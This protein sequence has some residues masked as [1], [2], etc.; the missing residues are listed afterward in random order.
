[1]SGEKDYWFPAKKYGWGWGIPTRWQG[2]FVIAAYV[3]SFAL[4][5]WFFPPGIHTGEFV[6]GIFVAS[7]IFVAVCWLKGEPPKWRWGDDGQSRQ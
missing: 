3:V 1:M 4:I 5:K 2:W 6:A 7:G